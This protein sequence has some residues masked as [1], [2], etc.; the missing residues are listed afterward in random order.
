MHASDDVLQFVTINKP[1]QD[2]VKAI[3]LNFYLA[4]MF[5]YDTVK[6]V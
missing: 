6:P 2:R 4:A 5:K 3:S 1:L